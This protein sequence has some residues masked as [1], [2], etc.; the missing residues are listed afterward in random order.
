MQKA[1]R[2]ALRLHR[3]LRYFGYRRFRD[4]VPLNLAPSTR[5]LPSS[6]RILI[7]KTSSNV[8]IAY[9]RLS[10]NRRNP[11][12][13]IARLACI[14]PTLVTIDIHIRHLIGNRAFAAAS[15]FVV[16]LLTRRQLMVRRR[17][18][19]FVLALANAFD[20]FLTSITAELGLNCFAHNEASGLSL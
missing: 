5:P 9:R 15:G 8:Q 3:K 18:W 10:V 16:V 7:V 17:E 11:S 13:S 1:E 2:R 14:L 12:S 4:R 20:H 19:F 6:G